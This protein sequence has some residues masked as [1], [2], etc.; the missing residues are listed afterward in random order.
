MG[1]MSFTQE[2]KAPPQQA[3]EGMR[4]RAL[5]GSGREEDRP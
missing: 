5:R 2:L 4:V 3:S 1:R